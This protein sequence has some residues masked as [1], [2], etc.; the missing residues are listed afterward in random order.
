[1]TT[2]VQLKFHR[3]HANEFNDGLRVSSILDPNKGETF[4]SYVGPPKESIGQ[5]SPEA[6]IPVL[7]SGTGGAQQIRVSSSGTTSHWYLPQP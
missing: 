3:Q 2:F 4:D 1:M 5:S 6:L 7:Q